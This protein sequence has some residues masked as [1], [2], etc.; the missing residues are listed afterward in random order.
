MWRQLEASLKDKRSA[1]EVKICQNSVDRG[2]EAEFGR[3]K[4]NMLIGK[5]AFC[6]VSAEAGSRLCKSLQ[7]KC[8]NYFPVF[9]LFDIDVFPKK[10]IT[11]SK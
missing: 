10:L 1:R 4:I 6:I 5:H 9:I 11:K 7:N 3:A 8:K 2:E